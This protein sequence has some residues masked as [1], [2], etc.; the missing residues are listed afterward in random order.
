MSFVHLHVHSHYSLLT[1]LP[2]IKALVKD[3][4]KKGFSAV[5]L[6]DY[7][8]M[9]GA[10]EFYETCLKEEIKPII[11]FEAFVAPGRRDDEDPTYYHLTLLA[12]NYV[13]YRNLMELSS[14]GA[15]EGNKHGKPRIDIE[16]LEQYKSGVI[17][18]S[19]TING[20]IPTLFRNGKID[21]AKNVAKKYKDLFGK[22]YFFLELQDH[23]A[24]PG[25]IDVNTKLIEL[26]TELDIDCVVTRDVHYLY[27]DDTHAQ[28]VL[29]CIRDGHKVADPNR[30]DYRQV[31][32]S[33]NV[34]S[35][36]TSRFRHIQSAIDNTGKIA[37]RINIEIELN[38]WHFAPIDL[39]PGKTAD[40]ELTDLAYTLAEQKYSPLTDEVKDRIAYELGIIIK[41]G[42]SPYFI[43]VADYVRYAKEQGIIETTRGSA[44]GSVVS[45]VMGITTV[46]PIRFK[47]PFE[48]FLNPFRP[49][50]PDIDTDFAD[51]RRD[52]MI[53]YVTEKYGSDRVAQIIT[54]G[55][56]AARA[57]V[58]DVGR[59]LGLSYSFC[60]QVAK[61]IPQGAQ[62]FPM[63]IERALKEEPDLK[64]LFET[65]EDVKRLL[66]L[67]QKVEGCARHTSIHAAGVVISPT[68][69]TDFTPVQYETGGTRLTTQYE[70][71]A[72]EAAGVL[73]MDFLGIRNLSIL[74]KAIEI[75]EKT[76][77]EKVDVYNLPLDDAKT[78]EMLSRGETEGTFQLSG[79]GMTR[80][81]KDL[82]P[83]TIDDIMA[84]VALYRPGPMDAIPEYIRRKHNPSSVTYLDP[85]MEEYLK[86]SFGLLVYQDDVL[87]TS[88]KLAG[89]NW[90]EADKFRKA[91]GKKIPEEMAKQKQK[92]YDGCK[93]YGGLDTAI[94]DEL[95]RQIEPFA[96]YGFNKAHAASYGIVAYQTSF[97]KA[98]YPVQYMTAVLQAEAGDAE[99]VA[100][101]VFECSRLSIDVLPPDI[102]ESFRN[103]A[104]VSKHGEPGRIR[105]GLFAIKNLGEHISD[106]IYTK[107]KEGGPYTSLENFLERV[108]DKDLNKKSLEALI[109]AGAMDSFG[110]D[111]GV[112]MGNVE[113]MLGY[114]R[115]IR[116]EGETQQFSLFS[117]TSISLDSK[118]SLKPAPDATMDQKLIW[119]KNLLGLYV[120]S[121]PFAQY[122]GFFG[123]AIT[124]LSQI[125]SMPRDSWVV[126]GGVIDTLT[127]KITKSGKI[128]MFATIQDRSGVM[129]LLV[130]PKTFEQTQNIWKANAVI[131]VVGKTPKE[132]GDNKIFVEKVYEL[133]PQNV[134]EVAGQLSVGRNTSIP[135]PA[136]V[137]EESRLEIEMEQEQVAMAA[138]KLKGAFMRNPGK[139]RVYIRVGANLLRTDILVEPSET[140]KSEIEGVVG[141]GRVK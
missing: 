6:T 100:A 130:F 111:R 32:R 2:T 81:L 73:K 19:G 54:F 127:K 72:V 16:L 31:D 74:G 134:A 4:K 66:T 10:I 88:I 17:V 18:L 78:F 118:L 102:N 80:W 110:F 40:E 70:M 106:V 48:R 37:D 131:V 132:E 68:K 11:G 55:T 95:W 77:G 103:F 34:E 90:E 133:T 60:D 52:D 7:G 24:I 67:A 128:M 12:E 136:P 39:P 92:F 59:A 89:Y 26:S 101:I 114:V 76:T 30:E 105:F 129:E 27:P 33:L 109:Q 125:E 91:M 46:D 65:N 115:R 13:G 120:S 112:L 113:Q 119:E 38:K 85:R 20:E 97:M 25:Q 107:R 22:E 140:L 117:G 35:D 9:Y 83:S 69:L 122:E 29:T 49:S 79:S 53:R 139:T 36:I 71:H 42:Y 47:L 58:R 62:G 45:Y 86:T 126:I 50:P 64:K 63:T 135:A 41:K 44:A 116:E 8:A 75:V 61:L 137:V 123:D 96:A 43:C 82:K 124:P 94:I 104:M 5:A 84:M 141:V 87:L 15:L 21:E 93:T 138:E 51:D 98:H 23:P 57:S 56:M 108:N 28:D 3:A 121:H 14:R 99:K 1:G